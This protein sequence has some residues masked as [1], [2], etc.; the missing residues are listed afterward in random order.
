[1]KYKI[2]VV[3]ATGFQGA[4]IAGKL[5]AKGYEVTTLKRSMENG[6]PLMAGVN[7]IEGGLDNIEALNKALKGVNSAVYTFPLIFDIN[8][9]KEY[10]SNFILAAEEQGVSLIVFNAGFDLPKKANKLLAINLKVEIKLMFDASNLNVITLVPDIYIDNISAPWSIPVI[11]NNKIVPYPVASGNKVP[12]ISH[13]DLAKFIVSAIEKPELASQ[14]LPI[15]G[16][17]YT[18]EE[19]AEAIA[20]EINEP[21]KFVAMTP[22]EFEQQI[23]PAFGDL[24]GKEISNLYRHIKENRE[25]LLSKD[26]KKTQ[27]ILDV[28]PQSLREW[29]KSVKWEL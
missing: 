3:G 20:S 13:A 14:V 2:F 8:L 29:V 16:N 17:L 26:F 25:E 21:I 15:G 11:L 19:I 7:A 10:T 28:V 24:E 5:L 27:D 4:N 18:G 1:M 23:T 9:A 6:T 22:D 12:W